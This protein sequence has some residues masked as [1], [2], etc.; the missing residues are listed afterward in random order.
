MI[1]DTMESAYETYEEYHYRIKHAFTPEVTI[2][3]LYL[4]VGLFWGCTNPFV[5]SGQEKFKSK[6]QERAMSSIRFFLSTPSLILPFIVNQMGSLLYYFILRTEP[7]SR[8]SPICNSVAF[9]FTAITG[10]CFFGEKM[11]SFLLMLLGTAC[12]VGGSYFCVSS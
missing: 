8:A 7:I 11:R 10:Y 6:L 4:L 2:I 5:K 12:V 3:C 1:I 9:L